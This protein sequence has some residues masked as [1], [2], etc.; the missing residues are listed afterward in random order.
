MEINPE[1]MIIYVKS[2]TYYQ[3]LRGDFLIQNSIYA[4]GS[5]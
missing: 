5:G 3:L 4:K 2:Y 1:M